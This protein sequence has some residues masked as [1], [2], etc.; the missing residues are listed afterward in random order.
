MPYELKIPVQLPIQ[1]RPEL[2]KQRGMHALLLRVLKTADPTLSQYIHEQPTKPFTQVLR[3]SS[4][5]G[6]WYWRVTW[7]QDDLYEPFC[8]GLTQLTK[9][10]LFD[11]PL[12]LDLANMECDY[13]SYTALAQANRMNRY[14]FS[15]GTPTTFKQRYYH[16]PIPDPYLC[17]QSWWRRWQAFAPEK[18]KWVLNVALLDIVQAHLVISHFR[19]QSQ[20]WH[21]DKRRIIGATG[22]MTFSII[23]PNK[24]DEKWWQGVAT[25][26]A[27]ARFCGTGHKTTQG[28]GQTI[29]AP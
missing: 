22:H 9:P 25:L 2:S 24:V 13:R 1:E 21:D 10:H 5:A 8:T 12:T 3:Y 20:M 27:F 19:V 7:M 26:A 15:F 14:R 28:L 11:Q 16:H 17:F 23:Q 6:A 18:L 4:E 29:L